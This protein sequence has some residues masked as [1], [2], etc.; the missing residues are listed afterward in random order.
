M[1]RKKGDLYDV[2]QNPTNDMPSYILNKNIEIYA[3]M[4]PEISL[5]R[6]LIFDVPQPTF[7]D[8][9]LFLFLFFIFN[10]RGLKAP[11]NRRRRISVNKILAIVVSSKTFHF[12]ASFTATRIRSILHFRALLYTFEMPF[13]RYLIINRSGDSGSLR[14]HFELGD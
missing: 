10:V 8:F 1:Q 12:S 7:A 9:S 3:R 13:G 14:I 4:Q 2:M 11:F 6:C 5:S